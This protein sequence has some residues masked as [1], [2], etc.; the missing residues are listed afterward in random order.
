MVESLLAGKGIPS[1]SVVRYT[2]P[3]DHVTGSLWE[4]RFSKDGRIF[5]GMSQSRTWNIDTVLLKRRFPHNR[6][7]YKKFLENTLGKDNHDLTGS[8]SQ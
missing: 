6:Y 5:F 2:Q 3:V 7:K 4:Y 8:P 1:R